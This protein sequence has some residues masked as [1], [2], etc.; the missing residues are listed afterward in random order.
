DATRLA[1]ALLGDSVAANVFLL[2]FA[3]QR[4]QLPVSGAAL[5]RALELFGVNVEQ[6]KLAFD[7]GRFTAHDPET[8]DVLA[9]RESPQATASETLADTIERRRLFL[10][11]YQ[12]AAYA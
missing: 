8:V 5:Y 10:T 1:S 7:W 12:D 11:D 2:G 4:G 9:A 6:N 3:F